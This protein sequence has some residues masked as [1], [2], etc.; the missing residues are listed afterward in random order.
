M[1]AS[2]V[3]SRWKAC[4]SPHYGCRCPNH[5][6]PRPPNEPIEVAPQ[7][8]KFASTNEYPT[9]DIETDIRSSID[10]LAS[11]LSTIKHIYSEIQIVRAA[12]QAQLQELDERQQAWERRERQTREGLTA[13]RSLVNPV[14][15]LPVEILHL[16]FS[17]TL[18][19]NEPPQSSRSRTDWSNNLKFRP[20]SNPLWTIELVCR[21]WRKVVIDHRDLWTYIVVDIIPR[22][23]ESHSYS[24]R[25]ARHL[26]RSGSHPLRVCIGHSEAVSAKKPLPDKLFYLFLS[27]ALRI[28]RLDLYLSINAVASLS[29]GVSLGLQLF[30]LEHL[31]VV[32]DPAHD[33]GTVDVRSFIDCKAL[34]EVQLY[35]VP[36]VDS[37][38]GL[39]DS[40]RK[41]IVEDNTVSGVPS[42]DDDLDGPASDEIARLFNVAGIRHAAVDI[43]IHRESETISPR[44]LSLLTLDISAR[45]GEGARAFIDSIAAPE[46]QEFAFAFIGDEYIAGHE[47][48][49]DFA[50]DFNDCQI[51]VDIHS[52]VDRS[53]CSLT[54]LRLIDVEPNLVSLE[55]LL[56]L[57]PGLLHFGLHQRDDLF[58][59]VDMLCTRAPEGLYPI[60]GLRSLELKGDFVG[61]D[62]ARLARRIGAGI[63]LE[64]VLILW[65]SPASYEKA[66]LDCE[67]VMCA[68]KN[69]P[70]IKVRAM[71]V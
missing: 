38:I 62:L 20:F 2:E 58:D 67:E 43:C 51:L 37:T 44:E 55:A 11:S 41:V 30:A 40:V 28:T 33:Y 7:H 69:T 52:F 34:R 3:N 45:S 17:M 56:S 23:I 1:I 59:V 26:S 68:S 29:D 19:Y 6:V 63:P 25:L 18:E 27:S 71:V 16:I 5:D 49:Q 22:N 14:R 36:C 50:S 35:N 13:H 70:E 48:L 65:E 47:P 39:P 66:V 61:W 31:V 24:R 64:N 54:T 57:L 8:R 60:P 9:V 32:G 12:L 10:C 4:K 42:P 15:R 53:H 46:L 21:N